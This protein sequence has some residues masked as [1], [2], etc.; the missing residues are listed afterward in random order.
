MCY[1][2]LQVWECEKCNIEVYFP[3][4]NDPGKLLETRKGRCGEWANC[5]SLMSRSMGWDTRLVHDETDH[6]WTEVRHILMLNISMSRSN[7][8]TGLVFSCLLSLTPFGY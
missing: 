1:F 4:Y 8:E 6:A 3:R 2:M 7:K 5:F